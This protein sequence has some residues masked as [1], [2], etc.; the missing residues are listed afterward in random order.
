MAD[1]F[2]LL[3]VLRSRGDGEVVVNAMSDTGISLEYVTPGR[4]YHIDMDGESIHATN[5]RPEFTYSVMSGPSDF[6]SLLDLMYQ[7]DSFE[8]DVRV[9]DLKADV[10]RDIN[11]KYSRIHDEAMRERPVEDGELDVD[12]VL[13]VMSKSGYVNVDVGDDDGDTYVVYTTGTGRYVINVIS[14]NNYLLGMSDEGDLGD[15]DLNYDTLMSIMQE[16]DWEEKQPE[17]MKSEDDILSAANRRSNE[18]VEKQY[19]EPGV[20]NRLGQRDVDIKYRDNG[21]WQDDMDIMEHTLRHT[22]RSNGK[23]RYPNGN[24]NVNIDLRLN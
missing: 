16:I 15:G 2:D 9:N 10:K 22:K 18:I 21:A 17:I 8:T 4:T 14:D 23:T 3:S 6:N 5:P 1:Q 24:G 19:R 13:Y 11:Q 20:D 7:I 12:D